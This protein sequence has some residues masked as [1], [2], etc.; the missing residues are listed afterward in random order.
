MQ[1]RL[2]HTASTGCRSFRTRLWPHNR[3]LLLPNRF[4][5]ARQEAFN[6]ATCSPH[7]AGTTFNG[8]R[9]KPGNPA[10]RH[11]DPV[12]RFR[13]RTSASIWTNVC[14]WDFGVWA[15]CTELVRCSTAR[16]ECSG[17]LTP[18]VAELKAEPPPRPPPASGQANSTGSGPVGAFARFSHGTCRQ[19]G[20]WRQFWTEIR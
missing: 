18:A 13:P 19:L 14:K 17:G 11:L 2:H 5:L 12:Q 8:V 7:A 3:D 1:Y 15:I 6:S 10:V 9:N 20:R 4:Q 16:F